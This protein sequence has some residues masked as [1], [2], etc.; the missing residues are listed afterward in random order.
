VQF[1]FYSRD[2]IR[3]DYRF[4]DCLLKSLQNSAS[5][6]TGTA[7]ELVNKSLCLC[8]IKKNVLLKLINQ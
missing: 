5:E 1:Q 7:V 2:C 3:L 8:Q 6:R 4:D